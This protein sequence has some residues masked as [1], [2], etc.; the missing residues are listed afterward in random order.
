M[1]RSMVTRHRD[2]DMSAVRTSSSKPKVEETPS[3]TDPAQT[4]YRAHPVKGDVDL[5][6][7]H[8]EFAKRYP[9]IR[10]FLAK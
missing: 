7:W 5:R 4:V 6:A 10:A 2:R 1:S 9:L 3:R 8:Q